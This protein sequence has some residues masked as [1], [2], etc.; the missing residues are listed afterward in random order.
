[1]TEIKPLGW[2]LILSVILAVG[3]FIVRTLWR[4]LLDSNAGSMKV[5]METLLAA[6]TDFR[7]DHV[8][9]SVTSTSLIAI[10]TRSLQVL[11]YYLNGTKIFQNIFPVGQI[12]AV[13]LNVDEVT[14]FTGVSAGQFGDALLLGAT[15][16]FQQKDCRSIALQFDLNYTDLPV[17]VH[18]FLSSAV[19]GKFEAE[20]AYVRDA[21]SDAI[22]FKAVVEVLMHRLK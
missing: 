13:H 10:D 9:Y 4:V 6:R 12:R 14:S 5:R 20:S 15:K 1:M 7:A 18:L 19:H 2:I 3:F 22:R 16:L 21:F 8:A 11:R 17:L